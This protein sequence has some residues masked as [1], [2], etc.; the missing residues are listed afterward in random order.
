MATAVRAARPGDHQAWRQAPV[1]ARHRGRRR[2]PRWRA[3]RL[4]RRG[5]KRAGPQQP[6]ESGRHHRRG[7]TGAGHARHRRRPRPAAGHSRL[8]TF[9][10]PAPCNPPGP[11]ERNAAVGA[12]GG[13]AR[14]VPADADVGS[15]S[16]QAFGR[17]AA[18]SSSSTSPGTSCGTAAALRT[19]TTCGGKVRQVVEEPCEGGYVFDLEVEGDHSYIAVQDGAGRGGD[20]R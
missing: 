15:G 9:G 11:L 1:R 5:W 18:A 2:V 13:D 16:P 20:G 8:G 19:R 17:C 10:E 14:E 12:R 4:V 3:G 7:P 6:R